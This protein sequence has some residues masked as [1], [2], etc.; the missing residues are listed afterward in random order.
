MPKHLKKGRL[1]RVLLAPKTAKVEAVMPVKA[2]KKDV[3]R[4]K[5]PQAHAQV[6]GNEAHT[7]GAKEQQEVAKGS[8]SESS[9]ESW[10]PA[11]TDPYLW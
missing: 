7:V 5:A 1:K 3:K 9:S 6:K 4:E 10:A 11:I 2:V 8:D